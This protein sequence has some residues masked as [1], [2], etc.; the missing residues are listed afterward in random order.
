MGFWR[1]RKDFWDGLHSHWIFRTATIVWAI[2]GICEIILPFCP[3]KW[4]ASLYGLHFLPR[5]HWYIWALGF[6]MLLLFAVFEGGVHQ[7]RKLRKLPV[8]GKRPKV[9]LSYSYE[10]AAQS[11]LFML[12][13]HGEI[14]AFE[15]EIESDDSRPFWLRHDATINEI[16]VDG[17][18]FL[19][20]LAMRREDGTGRA[21]PIGGW[22]AAQGEALLKRLFDSGLESNFILN[23]KYR[24]FDGNGYSDKY[25]AERNGM[26]P[27]D[28]AV[29]H[30]PHD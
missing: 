10:P 29:R 26:P 28:I 15:V 21:I 17:E 27:H 25:V 2:L 8:T 5:W 12:R 3:D 16:A 23:I 1:E 30:L 9:A 4:G 19:N 18:H 14:A 7:V 24:D 6:V 11:K 13:N 20:C 22:P